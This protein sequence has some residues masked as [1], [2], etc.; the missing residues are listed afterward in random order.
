GIEGPEIVFNVNYIEIP[1]LLRYEFT[2]DNPGPFAYAGPYVAFNVKCNTV[3]D[4]LPVPCADDDV[5]ANTVVGGAVGIG[6]QRGMW[7]FD[8]RYEY[9]FGD[10]IKQEDGHN[11]ALMILL[12]AALN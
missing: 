11:S 1:G 5:Q 7:G 6:F 9:D 3:V 2:P 8:I 12:R 10:A 4:T